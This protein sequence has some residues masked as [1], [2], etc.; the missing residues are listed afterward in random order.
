ME[1]EDILFQ[2]N[3]GLER[4]N[5]RVN[6]NGFLAKTK[7]PFRNNKNID[8]DFSESQTEFI[9]GV[10]HTTE[11]VW[12]ELDRLSTYA[13]R[14][15]IREDGK[16][17]YLWPFSNPPYLKDEEDILV[18]SFDRQLKDKEIYRDYLA[19]R[20][21]KK[22]MLFC[23]IH[24]NFS[25]P[26]EFL[27][28]FHDQGIEKDFT[29]FKNDCYLKLA[30]D[31]S[32]YS[33][34]IVHLTAASPVYD[35]S[36]YDDKMQGQ[37]IVSHYNSIRCGERGYWNEFVP[38]LNYH[39]LEE[40]VESIRSYIVSGQLKTSAELYLPVR[41][42]P[43]GENSLEKLSK[44]GID[45]IELRM[46]DLNPLTPMGIYKVDLEFL[47]LFLIYLMFQENK[48]FEDMEQ[49]MA[50]QNMKRAATRNECI[51]IETGWNQKVEIKK[52][53]L[54]ILE[55]MM[56][57]YDSCSSPYDVDYVL[58]YQ[59]KKIIDPSERYA[60]KVVERFGDDYVEKG[61]CF[62]KKTAIE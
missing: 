14:Y 43:K 28:N 44:E 21:G 18:A 60:Y 30:A 20:Y 9:T 31:V 8:R 39:S 52:A 56:I 51:L 24:Y 57:F 46:L 48:D 7:H 22:K 4:E 19:K 38:I 16:S 29:T 12:E 40:Y 41:L 55:D 10:C 50:V 23:G 34:L 32:R 26:D 27:R 59:I 1:N 47:H 17:E 25:F 58:R 5:L 15:L 11:E 6:K 36:L 37:S 53:A 3:I 2:G 42:K 45:H 35:G 54:D 13:K 62:V 61:M 49:I 33:W